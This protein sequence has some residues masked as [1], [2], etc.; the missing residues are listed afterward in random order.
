[1][2]V[3]FIDLYLAAH[4]QGSHT[5]VA[6]DG[7]AVVIGGEDGQTRSSR[8]R[9]SRYCA[10]FRRNLVIYLKMG[11]ESPLVCAVLWG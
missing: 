4:G 1:M 11:S 3:F 6:L 2:G 7:L 8:T 5:Q 9:A 10:H